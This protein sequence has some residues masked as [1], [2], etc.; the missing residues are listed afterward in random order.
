MSGKCALLWLPVRSRPI[1]A[2]KGAELRQRVHFPAYVNRELVYFLARATTAQNVQAVGNDI[3][4][5]GILREKRL[6]QKSE[7]CP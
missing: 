5:Q 4:R 2:Q 7:K 1:S 3:D 6:G